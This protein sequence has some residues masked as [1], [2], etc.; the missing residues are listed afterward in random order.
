MTRHVHTRMIG[1][2][3][4]T[5]TRI[6]SLYIDRECT[7]LPIP[8]LPRLLLTNTPP[9]AFEKLSESGTT[10]SREPDCAI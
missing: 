8:R 1:A 5:E 2:G 9:T 4:D 10:S 3:I 7:C 6:E